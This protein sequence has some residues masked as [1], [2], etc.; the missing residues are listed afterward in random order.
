MKDVTQKQ[1]REIRRSFRDYPNVSW[2]E[3]ANI[4]HGVK[5]STTCY[6]SSIEWVMDKFGFALRH[7]RPDRLDHEHVL[8]LFEPKGVV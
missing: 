5:I 3:S 6:T 8:A 1:L 2:V 7:V 4:I